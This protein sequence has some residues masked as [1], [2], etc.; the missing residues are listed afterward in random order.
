M[1]ARVCV[2]WFEVETILQLMKTHLAI[3]V[4]DIAAS[5]AEYTTMLA[6]EPDL[7]IDGQYAL[8]RTAS[9]NLSIRKTGQNAGTVRHVGFERDDAE[10]FTVLTDSNGLVWETFNKHH[11]AEEIRAAWG[12]VHYEPK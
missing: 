11:Q 6:Q 10:S 9:L 12:D 5:V 2:A 7:V 1:P 3:A 4:S 8:W